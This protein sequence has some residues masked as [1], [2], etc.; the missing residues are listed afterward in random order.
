MNIDDKEQV[1]HSQQ[2]VLPIIECMYGPY[3]SCDM[4]VEDDKYVCTEC[5]KRWIIKIAE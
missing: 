1:P 4:Y 5:G 3:C 2:I